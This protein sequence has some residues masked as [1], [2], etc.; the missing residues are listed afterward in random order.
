MARKLNLDKAGRVVIP[1]NLRDR[2]RITN[3]DALEIDG[4]EDRI[5]M[6]PL[7][8]KAKLAK[9]LGI[10]VYQG[11]AEDESVLDLV[12]REREARNKLVRG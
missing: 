6:R 4:D 11:R 8:V 3:G 2:L 10:W 5:T 12:D 1:K 7:R 9:E